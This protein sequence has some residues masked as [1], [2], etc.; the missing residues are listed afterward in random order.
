MLMKKI[1]LL[2]SAILFSAMSFATDITITSADVVTKEGI[3]IS[4]AKADGANSPAWFDKGLRLYA[5][6]TVTI[7][8]NSDITSITFNWE[9][10][11]SKDFASLKANVGSYSHPS[12]AGQATWTG[13]A[14]EIVFTLGNKGQLQLN[15]LSVITAG[16]ND[17]PDDGGEDT[18]DD[19]GEDT[20][21][22]GGE[23]T[24][25]TGDAATMTAGDN[26]IACTVNGADA[27]KVGSSK[28][29]GKM[30]I[31]VPAGAKT[32]RLYAAA[33]NNVSNLSVSITPAEKIT[34]TSI[35]LTADAG[36]KGDVKDFD[37]SGNEASY[38]Y[39][40]TLTNV[41]Q[42]T[43][44]TLSGNQRFVVWNATYSADANG[45]DTPDDGGETP[46][47]P[48]IDTAITGLQYAD[49]YYYT[50]E[51]GNAY[52]D[53]DLY[54]DYDSETFELIYPE[55]YLM[56]DAAKSRTAINGTYGLYWAGV[57]T[58]KNDSVVSEEDATTGSLTIKN[59]GNDGVYS[60]KGSF[61]AINGKTYTFD[62]EV[63]LMA[64]DDD[65][66][67]DIILSEEETEDPDVSGVEDV[68]WNTK[69]VKVIKNGQMYI[70]REEKV[71]NLLGAP[72]N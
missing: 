43:T 11:G 7:T 65:A 36:I 48:S 26:A 12:S 56:V 46:D 2:A 59:I 60:F 32:L 68:I 63:E 50:D 18:P 13:S 16:G 29:A 15:T 69:M 67:E 42:S 24:P 71:Y 47:T 39:E 28:N 58:S 44:F 41:N 31:T 72:A 45:D 6:N 54:A 8:A 9:K 3:T 25:V 64:Y 23:D 35:T 37:L 53:F 52:W 61:V 5:K 62:Q 20:P 4:F 51:K 70:I 40:F 55:L 27:I 21:D 57:W 1:L 33:W 14:R 30:T 49:A 22:D 34:P 66:G 17:T 19:G 10:Q 38:L